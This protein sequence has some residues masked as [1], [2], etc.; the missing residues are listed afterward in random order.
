MTEESVTKKV[1]HRRRTMQLLE[2]RFERERISNDLRPDNLEAFVQI[3]DEQ[4]ERLKRRVEQL[5]VRDKIHPLKKLLKHYNL[6]M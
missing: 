1:D 5:E 3:Q 4:I 6:F 2:E